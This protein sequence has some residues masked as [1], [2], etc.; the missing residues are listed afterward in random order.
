MPLLLSILIPSVNYSQS[1]INVLTLEDAIMLALRFN[2]EIKNVEIE[3]VA[4][5]YD[6]AAARYE[7]EWQYTTSSQGNS[8]FSKANGSSLPDTHSYELVHTAS[9][10]NSHGTTVGFSFN[11]NFNGTNYNPG[12]SLTFNQPL[13]RGRNQEVVQ[14]KLNNAI[15]NEENN[16]LMMKFR[17][18]QVIR[19][20]ISDYYNVILA[21]NNFLTAK[22]ALA[23]AQKT[24]H[25]NAIQIHSGRLANTVNVQ[26]ALQ[27]ASLKLRLSQ[28]FNA[29]SN[30][31][32]QLLTD[33]GLA[34]TATVNIPPDTELNHPVLPN[35]TISLKTAWKNNI[36]LLQSKIILRENKRA[37]LEASD[38]LQAQLDLSSTTTVGRGLGNGQNANLT[39][40][41]NGKNISQTLGMQFTLPIDEVPLKA[42]LVRAKINT[43]QT[44]NDLQ[45]KYRELSLTINNQIQNISSQLQQL[46][47]AEKTLALAQQSY[48]LE[49]T[50]QKF[51]RSSSLDVANSQNNLINTQL[52]LINAKIAYL[53][54]VADL[55][56]ILGTLLDT[57]HIQLKY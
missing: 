41:V 36:D 13:I 1:R 20:V 54:A 44:E 29:Q 38:N 9:K 11:H 28:A 49:K 3:R 5:K 16:K 46:N 33:I 45:Q 8:I 24:F 12:L 51:G 42:A 48:T 34:S 53:E 22:N 35:L 40:L 17:I 39:S 15:D 26:Q 2:P 25:D 6:L 37:I 57:W 27:V 31:R 18:M 47:I 56:V 52:S 43:A 14:A 10:K 55:E 23:D 4:Q 32:Y 21:N 50:K 30:A 19:K 7:F